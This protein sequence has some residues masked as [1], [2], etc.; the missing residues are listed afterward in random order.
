MEA[1]LSLFVQSVFI[2]NMALAFS[3]HVYPAGGLQKLDT[4]IGR[5]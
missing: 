3:G 5:L 4:A 1:Y 2:Q